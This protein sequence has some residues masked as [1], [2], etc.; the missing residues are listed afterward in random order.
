MSNILQ[1]KDLEKTYIS[2]SE[3]LTILKDLN[4]TVEEGS[5]VVSRV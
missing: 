3:R 1:I 5:K 2:D 4:L